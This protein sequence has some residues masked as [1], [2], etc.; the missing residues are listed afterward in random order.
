MT[1]AE[2]QAL[3]AAL[4][5]QIQALLQSFEAATGVQVHSVPVHHDNPQVT[6][7]VKVQLP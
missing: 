6:A 5:K 1:I 4:V 7:Q 3:R 2:I